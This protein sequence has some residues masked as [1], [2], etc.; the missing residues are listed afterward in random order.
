M[1]QLLSL[2]LNSFSDHLFED[3]YNRRSKP[4]LYNTFFIDLNMLR[5]VGRIMREWIRI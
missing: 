2:N 5:D 4:G 3:I 1:L